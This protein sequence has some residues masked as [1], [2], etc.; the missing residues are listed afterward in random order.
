MQRRCKN[1]MNLLD[2]QKLALEL[3]ESLNDREAILIYQSFTRRYTE[4]FLRKI[5]QKVLAIPEEKIRKSRGALF[6]YLVKQH[7]DSLHSRH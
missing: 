7:G 4:S 6:T 1:H 3:S 2:E 5:L